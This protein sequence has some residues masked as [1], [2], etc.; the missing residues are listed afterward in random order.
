MYSAHRM[1]WG[2]DIQASLAAQLGRYGVAA[3]VLRAR[4]QESQPDTILAASRN[5]SLF[6]G[7][8]LLRAQL[9]WGI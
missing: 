9:F 8:L 2:E 5:W 3:Q 7:V 6:V 1:P 4:E